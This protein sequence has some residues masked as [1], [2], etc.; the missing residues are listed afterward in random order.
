MPHVLL[1]QHNKLNKTQGFDF[2]TE[3]EEKRKIRMMQD[4]MA[5]E[6]GPKNEDKF[7]EV[8]AWQYEKILNVLLDRLALV[9]PIQACSHDLQKLEGKRV[10]ICDPVLGAGAGGHGILQFAGQK[11]VLNDQRRAIQRYEK[12]LKKTR[13][14]QEA[15][16]LPL[17]KY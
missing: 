14:Q 6:K 3:S 1:T 2:N 17:E 13:M 11:R 12:S 15:L 5:D 4:F 10:L 7:K 9:D 16:G 8:K